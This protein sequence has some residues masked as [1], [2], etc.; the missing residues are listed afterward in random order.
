[1]L[2]D[3]TYYSYGNINKNHLLTNINYLLNNSEFLSLKINKFEPLNK[4]DYSYKVWQHY[5]LTNTLQ[6]P[7]D[8]LSISLQ[9]THII[10][11]NPA[12]W[13]FFLNKDIYNKEKIQ[14]ISNTLRIYDKSMVK[15]QFLS[16]KQIENCFLYNDLYNEQLINKFK[17][18][19]KK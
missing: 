12:E 19:F 16:T 6:L 4:L 9:F 15:E 14:Y 1:M 5:H 18:V 3:C 17:V 7:Y 8:D 13:D 11:E 10:H 2:N